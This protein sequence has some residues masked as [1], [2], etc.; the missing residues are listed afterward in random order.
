MN[1]DLPISI[2]LPEEFY[3]EETRCGY[4]ITSD[5]K[6]LWAVELDLLAQLD[7]VCK[8]LNISYFLDAGN[9]L[10]AVRDGRFI[11]W[12]DDI[13]V[14]MLREDYDKLV[15]SKNSFYNPYFLQTPNSDVDYTRPH[16]Q[17]RNSYTCAAMKSEANTVRFNQGVFLDIFPL[18]GIDDNNPEYQIAHV[19][20]I[21]RP[22]NYIAFHHTKN[23]L[24]EM[25][26]IIRSIVYKAKYGDIHCI[27]ERLNSYLRNYDKTQYVDKV[28]FRGDVSK[29]CYLKREW[30]KDGIEIKFEGFICK[31]PHN[32]DAVLK[33]YY[34]DNYITPQ[35]ISTTHG[36]NG[37][38]IFDVHKSYR[39]VL[40]KNG[41]NA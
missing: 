10:G 37:G 35:K 34:G 1:R 31:I 8:M 38:M 26:R 28:S 14:V 27:F 12:D 3:N 23:K 32:Y 41:K 17:L 11:P 13:D 29:L 16:A 22:A 33:E 30:F 7:K 39:E 24:F 9:L 6:E 21:K 4:T 18:D 36:L 20:D 5:I 25:L 2:E 40:F 19:E 15:S